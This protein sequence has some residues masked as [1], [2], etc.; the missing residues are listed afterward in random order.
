MTKIKGIKNEIFA[1]IVV[2]LLNCFSCGGG[3]EGEGTL[4]VEIWGEEYIEKG[5]PAEVFSDRWSITFDKFLIVVGEIKS[6]RGENAPDMVA[7]KFKVYDLTKQGPTEI[8]IATVPAGAYDNTSY[9]I[10]PAD[11][12]TEIGNA[13]LDDLNLMKSN[14]FS[15]YIEGRAEKTGEQ[16]KNFKWGFNTNTH[17]YKCQST[18]RIS[19]GSAGVIQITIHGDHLF[20]DDLFSSEPNVTF[21]V[22]AGA[23]SNGDNEI[24]KEE[25]KSFNI[26]SL[27]NYQV[28]ST[29]IDNLWDF[30]SYLTKTLGHIDGE[31]HCHSE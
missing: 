9:R 25:L 17:Y 13:S 11:N 4:S 2:L 3:E 15:V 16:T 12:S 8:A 20:F 6:A 5:I 21:D 10:S 7:D 27:P 28:G 24:T 31:G 19:K 18:A 30:I 23:D 26:E 14:G 22:I 29:G 1:V